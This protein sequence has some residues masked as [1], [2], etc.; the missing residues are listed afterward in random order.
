MEES[1]RTFRLT[2]ISETLLSDATAS[3][4][5]SALFEISDLG[6][7]TWANVSHS[8]KT[9]KSALPTVWRTTV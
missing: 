2:P 1:E 7:L 5:A 6:R 3:L 4:R 8:V 9:G